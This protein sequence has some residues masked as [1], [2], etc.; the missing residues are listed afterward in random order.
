[1]TIILKDNNVE[2]R[3][4][5]VDAGIKLCP[6]AEFVDSDWLDYNPGIT[7]FVHGVGSPYEGMTKEDTRAQFLFELKDPVWCENVDEFIDKIKEN[8]YEGDKIQGIQP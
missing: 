3:R 8:R 1:M 6:C 2:I 4:K 5:I 7:E